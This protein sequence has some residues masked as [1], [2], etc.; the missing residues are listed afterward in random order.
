[1]PDPDLPDEAFVVNFE[2]FPGI[3][4][5]DRPNTYENGDLFRFFISTRLLL[6]LSVNF[7]KIIQTDGTYKLLW[8]GFP[9]ILIGSSGANRVFHAVGLAVVSKERANDFT[10]VFNS[11]NVGKEKLNIETLPSSLHLMADA[12]MSI[13]NGYKKT[14]FTGVRGM[15]WLK[16]FTKITFIIKN[17]TCLSLYI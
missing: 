8:Q 16:L 15:C 5:N 13:T 9:I 6:E 4:E 1:L 17:L 7:T 2:I 14:G 11:L 3:D 10:F 12:A